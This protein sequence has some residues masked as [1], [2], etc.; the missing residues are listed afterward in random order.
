MKKILFILF[1]MMILP[2]QVMAL[3]GLDDLKSLNPLGGGD[4]VD[5]AGTKTELTTLF[6]KSSALYMEAQAILAEAYGKDALAKSLRANIEY[7]NN[8]KISE[9][10]RMKNSIK[11]TS[12]A[13]EEIKKLDL[14]SSDA[15]TAEGKVLYAKS[16]VPAGK[17]VLTTIK[18]VPVAKNMTTN[19]T[20]NPTSALTELG[21]LVKVIP[22]LPGYIT[23]MVSTMKSILSGAKA[24]DIEG[25]DDLEASLGDL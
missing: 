8:S 22:N 17:G 3:P 25:A 5:F 10:D 14:Q 19:I 2:I 1:A 23:T 24:N 20:A 13:S 15:I 9:A 18:L 11:V 16:L 21:G 12:D 4:D 7:Q 6:F